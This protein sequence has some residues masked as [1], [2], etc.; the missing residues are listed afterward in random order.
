MNYIVFKRG[1]T[2]AFE[3]FALVQV[4]VWSWV[5][6][7]IRLASFSYSDW[8]LDPVVCMRLVS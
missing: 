3:V 4:K 6:T 7:N 8:Y 1:V 2:D 5:S